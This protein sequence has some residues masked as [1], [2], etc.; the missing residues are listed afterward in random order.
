MTVRAKD[1]I[2]RT[3]IVGLTYC[4]PD[5]S[6]SHQVQMHGEIESADPV[7]GVLVRLEGERD[8][9]TY[10]LPPQFEAFERARRGEYRL[11]E[12]GEVIHDPDFLTTWTIEM[13]P[14]A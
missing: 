6:F 13:P 9:E 1:L 11:R 12:T 2:G 14:D 5:G 4:D 7:E 8:G 3:V 10:L